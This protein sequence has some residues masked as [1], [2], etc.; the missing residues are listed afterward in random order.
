[1]HPV[2]PDSFL[3]V[4]PQ[5]LTPFQALS[6]SGSQTDSVIE[7]SQ[8]D[9]FKKH[10]EKRR[11]RSSTGFWIFIRHT[12]NSS[13]SSSPCVADAMVTE[14]DRPHLTSPIRP[15]RS[16]N[17]DRKVERL[18]ELYRSRLGFDSRRSRSRRLA[19]VGIV[20]TRL[21]CRWMGRART[22]LYPAWTTEAAFTPT[23]A[24]H[25]SRGDSVKPD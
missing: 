2:K 17:Q 8:G 22:A 13:Q 11:E 7:E 4:P 18:I 21:F 23:R 3:T 12:P 6:R 20:C 1:M 10:E 25:C 14:Q 5:C 16:E 24:M 19:T 15:E 9:H